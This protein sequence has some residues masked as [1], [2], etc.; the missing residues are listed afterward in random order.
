LDGN[1]QSYDDR[2]AQRGINY[3]YYI[4]AVGPV[5]TNSAG[6][7]PTGVRLKSGRYY[8]QTYLPANL[9]RPSGTSVDAIRIVPNPYNLGSEENLRW[10]DQQDKLGFLDIPGRCTIKIY[11]QLGELVKTIE[12]TDGSGDAFWDHTT[13]SRQV[14]ASGVYIAVIEDLD[15]GQKTF[16]NSSLSGKDLIMHY[17]L[18]V[19]QFAKRNA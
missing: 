10:P 18:Q 14:I 17:V 2:T 11:T 3:Y 7:T 5:N 1:A 4:Q 13:S 19:T 9:K 16:K 15:S 6:N 8:A 12:H